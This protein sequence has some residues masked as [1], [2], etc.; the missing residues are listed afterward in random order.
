VSL[1]TPLGSDVGTLECS[2]V[3]EPLGIKLGVL[4]GAPLGSTVG[5]LE[6]V[7]VG[8][9]LGIILGEIEG[10][11]ICSSVG[12]SECTT[13]GVLLG[14]LLGP[15]LEVSLGAL[16][17]STVGTSEWTRL[18]AMLKKL[19]GP[20]LGVSLG[21][22]LGWFVA[23]STFGMFVRLELG[24]VVES[25]L[26]NS[27]GA[28]VTG[29]S[30]SKET[31]V[32]EGGGV[33]ITAWEGS[34]V[35]ISESKLGL[36]DGLSVGSKPMTSSV[37][38][39]VS[40]E[41]GR[42]VGGNVTGLEVWSGACAGGPPEE[43]TGTF[44]GEPTAGGC[45]GAFT[46]G[47]VVSGACATGGPAT[48]KDAAGADCMGVTGIWT[49]GSAGGSTTGAKI[50][51]PPPLSMGACTGDFAP[52]DGAAGAG[53]WIGGPAMGVVMVV[54]TFTGAFV[55]AA[56]GG[57][58][59][60]ANDPV[61]VCTDGI[62][63]G[64]CTGTRPTSTGGPATG[65][66]V[67]VGAFTGAFVFAIVGGFSTGAD[68]VLGVCADGVA[69]GACARG[70]PTGVGVIGKRGT[71]RR[72]TGVD[73]VVGGADNVSPTGGVVTGACIGKVSTGV[74]VPGARDE[75]VAVTGAGTSTGSLSTLVSSV[76]GNMV[77]ALSPVVALPV[78]G[79]IGA[80]TGASGKRSSTPSTNVA[81]LLS[82]WLSSGG[83][84]TCGA[85][86]GAGMVSPFESTNTRPGPKK[87]KLAGMPSL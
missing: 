7:S 75:F 53:A 38:T 76:G 67:V 20:E 41:D 25:L 44:T 87:S 29:D 47:D 36:G 12:T 27:V 84:W 59:T 81:L 58:A 30:V 28:S 48:G 69:T 37:G 39:I 16:L 55:V 3:G 74:D 17:G 64:T 86:V 21:A 9:S 19:L 85:F 1:G 8:E 70:V 71:G 77:V 50:G 22:P 33:T 45:T 23:G 35:M 24:P 73:T 4:L 72:V 56:V 68:A 51:A 5:T 52:G 63:T 6:W 13:V 79:R 66:D 42:F 62:N 2:S 82:S 32:L 14:K 49:G 40:V 57:F 15:E 61:G 65:D 18:G 11:V 54:G 26:G 43:G 60:G 83:H 80:L 31:G 46:A 10:T 34:S 78:G